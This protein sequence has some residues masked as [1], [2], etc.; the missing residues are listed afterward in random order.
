MVPFRHAKE[1]PTALTSERRK[2][3]EQREQE[4]T[5]TGDIPANAEGG[6]TVTAISSDI[7]YLHMLRNAMDARE[8]LQHV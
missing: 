4:V 7:P 6:T 5:I 2:E 3:G 1:S 8:H